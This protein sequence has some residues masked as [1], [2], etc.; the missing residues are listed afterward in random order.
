MTT[1]D[2]FARDRAI[3][4]AAID[5]LES[6]GVALGEWAA[7]N[8]L[9]DPALRRAVA[10]ASVASTIVLGAIRLAVIARDTIPPATAPDA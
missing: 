2:P 4:T 6:G 9:G 10:D 1:P 8:A 5:D 7:D 3:I